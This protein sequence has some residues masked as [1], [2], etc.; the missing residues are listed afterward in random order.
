MMHFRIAAGRD[1]GGPVLDPGRVGGSETVRGLWSWT[2]LKRVDPDV[3]DRLRE[4]CDLFGRALGTGSL[5]DIEAHGAATSRGYA[6]AFQVLQAAAEPD[7]AYQ[8]GQDP[9]TGFRVAIGAPEGR[10][11]ARTQAS[12]RGCRVDHAR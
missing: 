5:A 7:D 9:L 3:H 11:R 2:V 1:Q 6:K 8:L 10:G 4:Q 12:R